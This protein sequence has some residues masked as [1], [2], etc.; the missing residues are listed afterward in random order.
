[1]RCGEREVKESWEGGR[2]GERANERV[3]TEELAGL[4]LIEK[5]LTLPP[6]PFVLPLFL[7]RSLSL[8][9]SVVF[10]SSRTSIHLT[11]NL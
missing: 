9:P 2:E 6:V 10:Q 8:P 7:R 1:M 3:G 5:T 4:A 11:G